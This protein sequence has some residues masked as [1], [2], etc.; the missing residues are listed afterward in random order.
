MFAEW[1]GIMEK[2]TL[3]DVLVVQA[4]DTWKDG[5]SPDYPDSYPNSHACYLHI[6]G[7]RQIELEILDFETESSYDDLWIFDGDSITMQENSGSQIA[8]LTGNYLSSNEFT[9]TGSS[10]TLLL[11]TDAYYNNYKGVHFRFRLMTGEV[12]T[13][14][15]IVTIA[16]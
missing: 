8:R 4:T 11:E 16:T 13:A 12:K 2:C 3:E 10:M 15:Q 14:L 1:N 5:Y 9:S 6:T 7:S